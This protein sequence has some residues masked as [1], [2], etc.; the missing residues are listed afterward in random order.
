MAAGK[1][2]KDETMRKLIQAVG[3][4]LREQGHAGIGVNK[5]A[6]RAGVSKPLIYRYFDSLNNLLKRYIQEKDYWLPLFDELQEFEIP[7]AEALAGFYTGILQE[8]FRFFYEEREMQ[9][10][11]LWQLSQRHPLL[12]HISDI[13]E[14]EGA[15]LLSLASSRF[16]GTGISFPA[17]TAIIVEGIYGLTLHAYANQ[18]TVC[19]IDINIERDREIIANTIGQL[20]G[21]AFEAADKLTTMM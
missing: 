6:L 9:A 12:R 14:K 11:I 20:I 18:S 2:D 3:E 17:I 1:R 21:W 19:G 7:K 13:R 15:K 10:L 4:I 8:Q 16:Q 5:I